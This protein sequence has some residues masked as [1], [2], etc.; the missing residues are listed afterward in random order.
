MGEINL[1]TG[2]GLP[3]SPTPTGFK[4]VRTTAR[5]DSMIQHEDFSKMP[6]PGLSQKQ[7]RD[8]ADL[9][10]KA[11][12]H[13]ENGALAKLQEATSRYL[14]PNVVY[15]SYIGKEAHREN[16]T[17]NYN[18]EEKHLAEIM[19]QTTPRE[20][21]NFESQYRVVQDAA[22]REL[23]SQG[24]GKRDAI[25][26][27][28]P[29]IVMGKYR[30]KSGAEHNIFATINPIVVCYDKPSQVEEYNHFAERA[31]L[32]LA[33]VTPCRHFKKDAD[34]EVIYRVSIGTPLTG[35]HEYH[36][37]PRSKIAGLIGPETVERI[38]KEAD[39]R[40]GPA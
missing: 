3:T 22:I 12:I 19:D 27:E 40:D 32:P 36:E 11:F 26:N 37:V 25:G 33:E 6:P 34:G 15:R 9:W 5:Y 16:Q 23:V 13:F 39:V 2:E 18:G 4:P 35:E 14:Q 38:R 24:L 31:K 7:M 1:R 29:T 10:D 21:V 20:R 28:E 8:L 30:D 17:G